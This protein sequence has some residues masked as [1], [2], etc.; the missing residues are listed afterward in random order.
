MA[1]TGYNKAAMHY[2][3]SLEHELVEYSEVFAV[4]CYSIRQIGNAFLK[5]QI[6]VSELSRWYCLLGQRIREPDGDL[7]RLCSF[8]ISQGE[9]LECFHRYC[10]AVCL[11][12]LE[13]L[14]LMRHHFAV[15]LPAIDWIFTH[16][17]QKHVQVKYFDFNISVITSLGFH[18][19]QT[20]TCCR[21]IFSPLSM[22]VYRDCPACPGYCRPVLI[23]T[24]MKTK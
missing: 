20:N 9:R 19:K 15:R 23:E 8:A 18:I 3:G 10:C 7:Y 24:I 1:G 4:K 6:Q 17:Q 22:G 13:L 21:N 12:M 16:L 5:P 11:S 2:T 14:V